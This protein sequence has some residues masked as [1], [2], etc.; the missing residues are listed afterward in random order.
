MTDYER[1]YLRVGYGHAFVRYAFVPE[2][3]ARGWRYMPTLTVKPAGGVWLFKAI[4]ETQVVK[5]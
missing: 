2:F 3:L 4:P 5:A 1:C